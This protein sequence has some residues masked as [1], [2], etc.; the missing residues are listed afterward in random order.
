[1]V[2]SLVRESSFCPRQGRDKTL[3]R[4]LLFF[5]LL[6]LPAFPTSRTGLLQ[7]DIEERNSARSGRAPF[8]GCRVRSKA[9]GT[10]SSSLCRA[11]L[12]S[13]HRPCARHAPCPAV[14]RGDVAGSGRRSSAE[15]AHGA[16]LSVLAAFHATTWSA[17][18]TCWKKPLVVR[19]RV[20]RSVCSYYENTCV[21]L[22][23]LK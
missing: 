15:G 23:F 11:A 7:Q 9:A 12:R 13:A 5:V 21:F 8:S 17:V 1:M 16:A 6:C 20:R 4:H 19:G 14:L 3:V 10:E 22:C 18:A 2:R